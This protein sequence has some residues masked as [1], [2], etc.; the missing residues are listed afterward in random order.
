MT[1]VSTQSPMQRFLA[2]V[3]QGAAHECWEWQAHRD[4]NGYGKFRDATDQTIASRW[5]YLQLH[6][7]MPSWFDVDHLCRN[8]ACVNPAHLEG[9]PPRINILRGIGPAA[10]FVVRSHCKHGHEF[11]PDNTAMRGRARVCLTCR[12]ARNNTEARRIASKSPEAM[13]ASR[14]RSLAWYHRNKSRA[15]ASPS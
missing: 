3:K 4:R 6:P 12:A 14:R 2:K 5:I 1:F 8:P 15:Q 11:T 10:K 7:D 9:V 13:A